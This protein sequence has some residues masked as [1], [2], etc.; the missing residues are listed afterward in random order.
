MRRR[1]KFEALVACALILTA[2]GGST[3]GNGAASE[4]QAATS[5]S[6]PPPAIVSPTLLD[7]GKF[8]TV[9]RQPLGRA[10]NPSSG[11]VV[12]AQHMAD[13]VI[14]PWDVDDTLI[15]PYLS[16]FYVLN[17]PSALQQ[18]GPESVAAAADRGGFV[19]G[20]ASSRQAKGKGAMINAVLRFPDPTAAAAAS[21]TM[22]DASAKQ[23][24]KGV[25]PTVVP[26]PGHPAAVAAWYPFVAAESN[27]TLATLRSFTPHGP[28]VLMQ[29][30]QSADG[31]EAAT[32]LA[33]KAIDA[34][35]PVI[36]GFAP[37]DPAAFADVPLDPTGLLAKTLPATET[38]TAK[39]AVYGPRGAMHFQ[40]NPPASAD[41]FKGTGTTQIA[42]GD[43]NVYEAKDESHA[44]DVVNNFNLEV[45]AEGTGPAD[46]VKALPD[47]HCLAFPKGYYCIAPAGR[48][49]IEARGDQLLEAQQ[50]L[51]AQYVMLTAT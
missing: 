40:S 4:S 36:D 43:T 50:K 12:D 47:S 20:F 17:A 2:C 21:V 26:V 29:F 41:L 5:A 31:I 30:V 6:P 16:A 49:A 1:W 11:A 45:T 37:A 46:P 15:E 27:Q 13:F 3:G 38:T 28:Y 18:I 25:T 39:N 10:G 51:A 9:P 34:Q 24:I 14:G 48:Y 33:A 22:G 7:V 35:G 42:M 32:G 23:A 19:N 8:P 44:V